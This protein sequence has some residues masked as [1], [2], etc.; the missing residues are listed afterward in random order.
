[1]REVER[2][3]VLTA[4]RDNPHWTLADLA[5]AMIA[6]DG[7]AMAL[8]RLTVGELYFTEGDPRLDRLIV[9]KRSTGAVFDGI[10]HDVLVEAGRPVRAGYVRV[11]VGGPC[12]KVQ[13][14]LQRLTVAKRIERSGN[15]SDTLY[16][17]R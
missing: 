1:M 16:C 13:T 6:S 11:R 5:D 15:T 8:R 2:S 3:A 9:A 14:S 7:R 10:V 12:W 17:A 4:L